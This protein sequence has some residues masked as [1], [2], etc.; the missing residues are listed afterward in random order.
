ML[1]KIAAMPEPDR[2]IAE[3]VHT[4][5]REHA[6]QLQ[7]KTWYGMP[8]YALG[9]DVLCFFQPSTQFKARY[10]TLGFSDKATLD[11]GA[12]WPTS[13]ALQELTPAVE[14]RIVD[15]VRQAAGDGS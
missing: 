7:P 10:S 6:P 8:A 2:A 15:L 1:A 11:E 13:F 14:A 12:M 5:I 4:L 9:K 3:R